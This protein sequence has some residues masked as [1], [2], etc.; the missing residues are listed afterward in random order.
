[1][2]I[3]CVTGSAFIIRLLVGRLPEYF[4]F[5]GWMENVSGRRMGG[6]RRCGESKMDL[7]NEMIVGKVGYHELPFCGQSSIVSG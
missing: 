4:L 2:F 3:G 6:K 1:M 5:R 7:V